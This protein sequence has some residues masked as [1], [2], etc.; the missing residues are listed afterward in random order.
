MNA[1]RLVQLG[2]VAALCAVAGLAFQPV[3]ADSDF[4]STVVISAV[5]AVGLWVVVAIQAPKRQ[6]LSMLVSTLGL[7]FLLANTVLDDT[8]WLIFPT[9]S[10]VQD[11]V[12]GLING[13]DRLLTTEI[14]VAGT[15]SLLV[16]PP[17]LVWIASFASADL[18]MRTRATLSPLVPAL[19]VFAAGTFFSGADSGDRP[20]NT[21]LLILLALGLML[22][23]RQRPAGLITDVDPIED[24]GRTGRLIVEVDEIEV[25]RATARPRVRALALGLGLVLAVALLAP[26]LS[27]AASAKEPYDPRASIDDDPEEREDLSPLVLLKNLLTQEPEELFTV[28]SNGRPQNLRLVVLDDFDGEQ[29]HSTGVYQ[30]AGTEVP[31]P[32][33]PGPENT[34]DLTQE[35]DIDHLDG[36]W[37]PAVPQVVSVSASDDFQP[38]VQPDSGSLVVEGDSVDGLSYVVASEVPAATGDEL[39]S[40]PLSGDPALGP[41][42]ELPAPSGEVPVS[43]FTAIQDEAER[44]T[45]GAESPYATMRRLESYFRSGDFR[46]VNTAAPGHSYGHL[47]YFLDV[48]QGS[49]EHF[50]TA[51]VVMARSVGYPARLA[52]G[53]APGIQGEDGLYHVSSSDAHAWPEVYFE[54]LGWI[55]FEPNPSRAALDDSE[56]AEAEAPARPEDP[57]AAEADAT[58]EA[59]REAAA[60]E[61]EETTR[62]VALIVVSAIVLLVVLL[63]VVIAVVRRRRRH[64]RRT[65]GTANDRV[66]GAYQDALDEF[67]LAG[68]HNTQRLTGAELAAMA[69][70][71]FGEVVGRHTTTITTLA[72]E[73]LFA[74]RPVD[75]GAVQQAWADAGELRR[76]LRASRGRG[77]RVLTAFNPRPLVRRR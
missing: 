40:A 64:R 52:V 50:A 3:Y 70:E 53:F 23:R 30:N 39:R 14:P 18:A 72:N 42:T 35:I 71:Q 1:R 51:F 59:E 48:Q 13:W 4:G 58:T 77:S 8:A 11:L 73:A 16:I 9:P 22:I 55:P 2:I 45:Q 34:V 60:R 43:V 6:G 63:A 54:G 12:S 37:L 15:T 36:P 21:A 67:S 25:H 24:A 47:Q 26:V 10:T 65:G 44:V 31:E 49:A 20:L 46:N 62:R 33:L 69:D 66:V 56:V 76:S 27:S 74:Q 19:L 7:L 57:E 75:E 41:F 38:Q 17:T 68:L 32:S 5:A 29:W 61:R 28:R